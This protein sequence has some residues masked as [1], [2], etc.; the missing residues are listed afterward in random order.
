[1]L[2]ITLIEFSVLEKKKAN[3]IYQ[4]NR[5]VLDGIDYRQKYHSDKQHL[6]E[7]LDFVFWMCQHVVLQ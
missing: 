3:K 2:L 7:V 6:P 5:M 4:L 1:M